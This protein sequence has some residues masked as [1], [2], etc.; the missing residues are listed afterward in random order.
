MELSW[1][2]IEPCPLPF[3]VWAK[4]A[5]AVGVMFAANDAD[6]VPL[7]ITTTETLD[8]VATS[9]G[10]MALI[11]FADTKTSGAAMPL[12]VTDV[13][14]SVVATEPEGVSCRRIGGAG[15]RFAREI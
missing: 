7:F 4:I 9:Y 11:W 15:P 8:S 10:T 1:L 2:R 13:L 3:C 5:G 12:K 6:A 14:P